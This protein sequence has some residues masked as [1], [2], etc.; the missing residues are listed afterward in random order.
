M[1]VRAAAKSLR[2]I[3]QLK[4]T[5][6]GIRPP[7][8]RRFLIAS[9][10]SL[11]DVHTILQI[12]IGW[13]DSHLHEFTKGRDRYGMPDEDFPE[14]IYDEAKYRLDQVLKEEKEKL[15]YTYDFG[16]GW[17]HDV[18]LEKIL[19]FEADAKLP[20]CLK[21]SRACPPEDIGGVPGYA[22]F[23]EAISDPKHPEHD[24]MLEWIADDTGD[25]F[26]PERFDLDEVNNLLQ[27]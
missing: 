7:I 26:D 19:P 14:D 4:V 5:L 15:I 24:S 12:V 22:M 16:D 9:T 11:A 25:T 21:G 27:E 20:L 10:A 2:S 1:G 18:V 8:W 13:T 3:Y 6:K 17:E 23:L